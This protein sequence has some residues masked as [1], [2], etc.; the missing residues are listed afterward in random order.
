MFGRE[1]QKPV[2]CGIAALGSD[3]FVCDGSNQLWRDTTV[4]I[5]HREKY[6][7]F[8]DGWVISGEGTGGLT[9]SCDQ[10]MT[11]SLLG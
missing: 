6:V 2:L 4:G 1:F 5:Q 8:L 3:V 11:N 9:S 10:R 7:E